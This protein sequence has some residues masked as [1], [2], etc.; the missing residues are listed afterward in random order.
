MSA[1]LRCRYCRDVI[2]TYEPMI[3]LTD[4]QKREASP[5]R[6]SHPAGDCYHRA[7]FEHARGKAPLD[8]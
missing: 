5:A 6:E 3:V 4:G 8:R 7:C 1:P 2:G